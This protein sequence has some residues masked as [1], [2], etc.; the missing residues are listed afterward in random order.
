MKQWIFFFTL[1]IPLFSCDPVG[2]YEYKVTNRLSEE[3]VLDY[4]LW[5]EKGDSLIKA[6]LQPDNTI[7]IHMD[8]KIVSLPERFYD[9]YNNEDS[10]TMAYLSV[11]VKNKR[12]NKDFLRRKEW[13]Y[14]Q[15]K[16]HLAEYLLTIDSLDLK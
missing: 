8:G 6:T 7:Q 1:I 4:T 11:S 3:I 2:I 15:I 10:I 14:L 13:E 5:T 12:L 9:K 16:N